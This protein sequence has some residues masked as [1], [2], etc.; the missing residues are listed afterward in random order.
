MS[1]GKRVTDN[2]DIVQKVD[3]PSTY[4]CHQESPF[5]TQVKFLGSYPL[6]W[7]GIQVSGTFQHSR[8]DPTGGARFTAMGMSAGYVATNAVIAPSLGRNLSA[9]TAGSATIELIEPGSLYLDYS[10]QLDLRIAKTFAFGAFRVQGQ[11]DTYNVFNANP[12]LRYNTACGTNGANWMIPQ[13]LLP[14]RL[15]RLGVQVNF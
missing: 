7:Y 15:I 8:P 14:G 9:G 3:N 1:T 4:L 11:V 10:N 13:A 5:L 12:V 2:C 6:P